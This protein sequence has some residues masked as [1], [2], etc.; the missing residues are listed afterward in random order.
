M[1]ITNVKQIRKKC[2]FK[3]KK[4]PKQVFL[5]DSYHFLHFKI[6]KTTNAFS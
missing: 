4:V 3:E 5:H 2:E 1:L 6:T